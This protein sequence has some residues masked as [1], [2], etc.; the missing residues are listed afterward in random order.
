[1]RSYLGPCS[2]TLRPGKLAY[3]RDI[4]LRHGSETR[5]WNAISF[6]CYWNI[7]PLL[8]DGF[9]RLN[10]YLLFSSW[11]LDCLD[12]FFQFLTRKEA[13]SMLFVSLWTLTFWTCG[14]HGTHVSA[15]HV[16]P[17]GLEKIPITVKENAW[18]VQSQSHHWL[19]TFPCSEHVQ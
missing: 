14:I 2:T 11:Y 17:W 19:F 7:R 9:D 16:C 1:M 15:T 13:W 4:L 18:D 10:G 3:K 8:L 6:D 5:T 12:A